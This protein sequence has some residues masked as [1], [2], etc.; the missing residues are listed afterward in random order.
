MYILYV[1]LT[2]IYILRVPQG[3]DSSFER[4]KPS[5]ADKD[6]PPAGRRVNGTRGRGGGERQRPGGGGGGGA[7]EVSDDHVLKSPLIQLKYYD[8]LWHAFSKVLISKLHL[9]NRV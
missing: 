5:T 2:L 1:Y 7:Q 9:V 3:G 8:D 4:D 6:V